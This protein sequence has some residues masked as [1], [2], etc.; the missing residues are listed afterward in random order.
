MK[1]LRSFGPVIV[2]LAALALL[3]SL[4][5]AG[6]ATP[7]EPELTYAEDVQVVEPCCIGSVQHPVGTTLRRAATARAVR[8]GSPVDAETLER[9]R[10]DAATHRP[11]GHEIEGDAGTNPAA[12]APK[13]RDSFAGL[14]MDDAGF[15]IPP[16]TQVAA[17]PNHVLQAVNVA[18]RL[19]GRD[20]KG[21][22]VQTGQEHFGLD[23]GEV[24]LF[25]PKLYYDPMSGRFF[26]VFMKTDS[27]KTPSAY[28][29]V[30]R[31]NSPQSLTAADED[32]YT[33]KTK[34]GNTHA[35]SPW[36]GMTQK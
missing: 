1:T 33:I 15:F 10:R 5:A 14:G 9:M 11:Q 35:H 12:A 17:G 13:S 36:T 18:L 16:D 3:E 27:A 2:L 26:L 4:P 21:A 7:Q 25:D 20:G 19:S 31:S 34:K 6:V 30:S 29:S 28:L 22:V 24:F 23:P 8:E 32:N